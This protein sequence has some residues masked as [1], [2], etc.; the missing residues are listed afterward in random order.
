MLS[1]DNY[2]SIFDNI[3][4]LFR[5]KNESVIGIDIGGSSAKVVQLKNKAG[6]AVLETYGEVALGPYVGMEIGRVVKLQPGE[7]AKALIDLLKESNTTTV[8]CGLPVPISSSLIT[9]MKVPE[10]KGSDLENIVTMEAQRY[11]PVSMQEITLD[12]Q[13]IPDEQEINAAQSSQKQISN[14]AYGG[15]RKTEAPKSM[16]VLI[17]AVHSEAIARLKEVAGKASLN[18]K[19]LELEAF[20]TI[21]SVMSKQDKASVVI[22]FG[23][24]STK[25]YIIENGI[26]RFSHV[27]PFGSQ[28][29]TLSISRSAGVSVSEAERLK[30]NGLN[31]DESG[32]SIAKLVDG[33][34]SYLSNETTKIIKDYQARNNMII[35]NAV[36]SGGGVNLK[37]LA[38]LFGSKIALP[39]KIAD[40]FS[41]LVA[42][43]FLGKLL[44]TI[45]PSYSVAIGS[46]L[47]ALEEKQ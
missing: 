30:V 42:P 27:I 6:Q 38:E 46:A 29:V 45:G 40:P 26:I 7:L 1:V 21:R 3:T 2:M 13:V 11:I 4:N 12:W 8:D 23:A 32:F 16:N 18:Y 10:I 9:T 35:E 43:A 25:V 20:S 14:P 15:E 31:T 41:N 5:S 34:T 47:R 24:G 33:T 28:D 17:V 22:D 39:F 44:K 19:F 37:G 36:L